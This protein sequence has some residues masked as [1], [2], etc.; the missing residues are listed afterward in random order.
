[1][2]WRRTLETSG[3][4]WTI[5][6]RV[7]EA[8]CDMCA[9]TWSCLLTRVPRSTMSE[10]PRTVPHPRL[11]A[12]GPVFLKVIPADT[13]GATR[14]KDQVRAGQSCNSDQEHSAQSYTQKADEEDSPSRRCPRGHALSGWF[15]CRRSCSCHRIPADLDRPLTDDAMA[16]YDVMVRVCSACLVCVHGDVAMRALPRRGERCADAAV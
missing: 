6:C 1:V 12:I 14:G 11:Y 7:I 3:S 2:W 4:C 8:R 10:G 16:K 15:A 5:F 9:P 13:T